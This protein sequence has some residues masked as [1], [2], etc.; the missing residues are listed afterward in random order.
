MFRIFGFVFRRRFFWSRRPGRPPAAFGARENVLDIALSPSGG[1]VAFVSPGPGRSPLLYT[2][3]VG[4]DSEP[5]LALSADG[6][7]ERLSR[8]GWVSEQRLICTVYLVSDKV[9]AGQPLGATRLVAVNADG[10]NVK[11][12]SR[13]SRAYDLY[14]S[15][16]G[17]EVI[18]WQPGAEGSVLMGREYVPEGRSDS[19]LMDTREGYGVDRIDSSSLA[20]KTVEPA[21]ARASDY[22]SDGR[23]TVRI[24]AM[25]GI[26]GATG[27]ESG[28]VTYYYRTRTSRDWK[29]LGTFNSINN[30]GFSARPVDP[31]LD[32]AYASRRDRAAAGPSTVSLWTAR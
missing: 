20:S 2:V 12:L 18:D 27:Y 30:E 26:A 13:R 15:F 31:D 3:P 14:V 17:G 25:T 9:V 24:M 4:S 28:K 19:R 8:C 6:K 23:G 32:V 22:I 5:R 1:R 10:S 16:G 29:S 21:K 7:P 11:L